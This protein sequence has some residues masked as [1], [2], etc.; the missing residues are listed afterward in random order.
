M[1]VALLCHFSGMTLRTYEL[2]I[3]GSNLVQ[4]S[5]SSDDCDRHPL[6]RRKSHLEAAARMGMPCQ[7]QVLSFIPSLS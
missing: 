5:A 4:S 1:I 6:Q 3:L 7:G 2:R